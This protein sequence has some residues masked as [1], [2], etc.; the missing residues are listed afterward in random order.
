MA[1]S[2]DLGAD[3]VDVD[4]R[5][6]SA[7]RVPSP[8]S[9]P[10]SKEWLAPVEG[11][12]WG[13]FRIGRM[14]GQGGMGM[15]FRALQRSLKR[16]VAL[17]VL[18]PSLSDSPSFR[19]RFLREAQAVARIVSPHVAQVYTGGVHGGHHYFA[20]EYVDGEDLLSRLQRGWNPSHAQA[21]DIVTQAA[22]G[23]VAAGAHDIVHR[24]IKPGNLI[25]TRAGTVKLL[26]FGLMRIAGEERTTTT[27]VV[28]GTPCYFSPEQALGEASDQRSDIYSLGA[29]FFELL[30]GH[31]PFNGEA[32]A[33]VHAHLHTPPPAL[34]A[35]DPTIP[36][37]WQEVVNTCL[38]KD[39]SARYRN[40]SELV[41]DLERLAAAQKPTLTT[42]PP[43]PPNPWPLRVAAAVVIAAAVASA[44]VL[45]WSMTGGATGKPMH[46]NEHPG[47]A[48]LR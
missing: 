35:I 3:D 45:A 27:G 24:D 7:A 47:P 44:G 14:I 16:T 21:L 42:R 2:W 15:V 41:A 6:L 4:T 36:P 38:A 40:A 30:A 19:R 17:K 39:P 9:Q 43:P 33:V 37:E 1:A 34:R 20:M 5:G 46:P 29:V 23:L 22:R 12:V 13:D 26:D 11:A 18:T 28:I 25:I 48:A 31:P 8:P 10:W 32:S